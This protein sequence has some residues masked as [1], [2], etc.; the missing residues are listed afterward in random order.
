VSCRRTEV[1]ERKGWLRSDWWGR[2]WH[3]I[4][5]RRSLA[6]IVYSSEKASL[7]YCAQAGDFFPVGGSDPWAI[8]Q[9]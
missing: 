2:N 8:S 7:Q 3:E 1:A 9:F 4:G 6:K 5:G